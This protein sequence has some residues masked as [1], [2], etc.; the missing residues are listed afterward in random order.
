[1]FLFTAWAGAR[2][3]LEPAFDPDRALA[4]FEQERVT[5]LFAVPQIYQSLIQH[6]AWPAADL[7]SWRIASSGGAPV[8]ESLLRTI[9]ARG[10][11]MLQGYSLTE[12]SAAATVLPAREALTRIGSAGLPVVHSDAAVLRE[13]GSPCAPEEVGE[14]VVRGPQVMTGYWNNPAATAETLRD[15]WLHTGDLGTLDADGYLKVVD[16][17]KDMLISG[18]LNVYPAEIERLLT[19]LPGVAELT[20]IGVP[21]E[22]WGE[23]PMLVAC[24]QEGAALS[25]DA[26][27]SACRGRLADYKHPRFLL[28]RNAP[29]PRSMSG[30]VLKRQLRG[31]YSVLPSTVIS[32]ERRG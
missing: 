17:A 24:L 19:G 6:P 15:G 31:E 16:R 8:P 26:V 30:K 14:I 5:A 3:V 28:L 9:Q 22:R 10:V 1:V 11:P 21:H 4:L 20:V 13:D 12:A 27:L 32:L 29:L 7:G 2:L 23:T 25:A 18:G